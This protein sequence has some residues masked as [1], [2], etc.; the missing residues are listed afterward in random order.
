MAICSAIL[1]MR[2]KA[3]LPDQDQLFAIAEGQEGYF[4]MAQALDAGFARS[5]HS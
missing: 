1:N 5:T 2:A 4:T 3:T